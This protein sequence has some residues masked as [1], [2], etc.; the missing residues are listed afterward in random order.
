[1]C[2]CETFRSYRI[3]FSS[4][5]V[6]VSVKTIRRPDRLCPLSTGTCASTV[7]A[8]HLLGPIT[9]RCVDTV[10][11]SAIT[12]ASSRLRALGGTIGDTLSHSASTA[13]WAPA[14][15]PGWR[16]S[17]CRR[18][19]MPATDSLDSFCR[20]RWSDGC[21][22]GKR[23]ASWSSSVFCTSARWVASR[24]LEL[25]SGRRF[26]SFEARRR[27]TSIHIHRAR[28]EWRREAWCAMFDRCAARI[29]PLCSL[30]R[31]RCFRCQ[32]TEMRVTLKFYD[33]GIVSLFA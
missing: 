20:S 3:S 30:C 13:R 2:L 4:G 22:P 8:S 16:S 33:L 32:I 21:S 25:L 9:V 1:M 17:T 19:T 15:R 7:S 29:G 12:I 10:S 27:T 14:T 26:S 6:A 11:L 28:F 24:R 23:W 5:A 31:G 18:I